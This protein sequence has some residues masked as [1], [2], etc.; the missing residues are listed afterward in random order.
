MKDKEKGKGKNKDAKGKQATKKNTEGQEEEHKDDGAEAKEESK[1]ND[2]FTM[3]MNDPFH[4]LYIKPLGSIDEEIHQSI[5][6]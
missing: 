4:M 3:L 1:A 2:D 6:M 5:N